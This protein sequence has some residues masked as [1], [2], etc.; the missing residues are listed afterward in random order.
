MQ[1]IEDNRVLIEE[2]K[3][4]K[5]I[6]EVDNM[7]KMLDKFNNFEELERMPKP[8]SRPNLRNPKQRRR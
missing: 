2:L 7:K 5:T 4:H 8:C 1:E 3:N 6:E